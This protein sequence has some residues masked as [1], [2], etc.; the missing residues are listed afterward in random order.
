MREGYLQRLAQAST[1]GRVSEA[2]LGDTIDLLDL[3]RIATLEAVETIAAWRKKKRTQDAYKWNNLNYLLKIP[4][5]LDFLQKHTGLIQWLGFTL[6]RNPFVLPLNLDC[7]ARVGYSECGAS[8]A[9]N[10]HD[11][12]RF[13]EV[14]GKRR[15]DF[16]SEASNGG[17]PLSPS[18]AAAHAAALAERKRA[19]NPYETR[20]LNDE[21][22]L[23]LNAKNGS[24]RGA[25]GAS[26]NDKARPKSRAAHTS[27]V[28]P[29][30]IAELDMSRIRDAEALILQEE[31]RF[32]RFTRDTQG[33]VVPE[34]EAH[35]RLNMM[36]MSGGAYA[37]LLASGKRTPAT[38]D[39]SSTYEER[40]EDD[41]AQPSSTADEDPNHAHLSSHPPSLSGKLHAKKKAGMLGPISKPSKS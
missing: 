10:G 37:S 32:G 7:Q 39:S 17:R 21:E 25:P 36:E 24:E 12:A 33:L 3:L 29:S 18:K 16:S 20:V 30:Q 34:E 9:L 23:P 19:K 2:H 4:S 1:H 8:Q 35:R 40:Q 11:S 41:P 28:V 38:T 15:L 5:D 26:F 13:V 6:E 14:G 31:S 27:V 22:L